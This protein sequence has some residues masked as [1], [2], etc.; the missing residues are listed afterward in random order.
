MQE[1]RDQAVELAMTATGQLLKSNLDEA[2]S[3][4]LIDQA[5]Q[6]LGGKLH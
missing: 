6:E 5:I 1:V 2:K 3:G 4:D